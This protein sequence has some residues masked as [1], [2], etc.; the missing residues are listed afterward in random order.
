MLKWLPPEVAKLYAVPSAELLVSPAERPPPRKPAVYGPRSEYIKLVF[1]LL[2]N[3]MAEL[4]VEPRVV[5]GVF[6]VPKDDGEQRLIVDARNCNDAFVP[7]PHVDLPTPDSLTQMALD[8][9]DD[10]FVAK[11]DLANYYNQWRVPRWLSQYFALP[12]LLASTITSVRSSC[13]RYCA[14]SR[15]VS[16]TASI[17]HSCCTGISFALFAHSMTLIS[18]ILPLPRSHCARGRVSCATLTI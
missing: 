1:R 7:S 17:W 5:N 8:A 2:A 4:S 18:S 14:P 11:C 15:W 3:D 10:L 9:A 16:R 13:I 12:P 6:V